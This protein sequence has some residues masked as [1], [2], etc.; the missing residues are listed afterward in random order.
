MPGK[1]IGA[2]AVPA[3][4]SHN[5]MDGKSKLVRPDPAKPLRTGTVRAPV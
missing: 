3:R 5:M 2:P 1:G 4:S